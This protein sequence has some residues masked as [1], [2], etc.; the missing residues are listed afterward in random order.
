MKRSAFTLIE[1]LVVIAIIA[2]LAAILFPVFAQA[3]A[4]AKKTAAL[5]NMK[6]LGTAI[7]IYTSDNDDLYPSVY[8]GGD[9]FNRGGDPICTMYPYVKNMQIWTGYRQ[10]FKPTSYS[11]DPAVGCQRS[12][13]DVGYNWGWEIRAAEG[14]IN[15]ERCEDG[16][17][18]AGCTGRPFNGRNA[19][20]YNT[21]KSETQVANPADLFAF[22]NSYDTPRQTMGGID[23]FFDDYPG[24]KRNSDIYFGGKTTVTFADSHAKSVAWHG[25]EISGGTLIGS[26]KSFEQ[27]VKGYCADPDGVVN[28]FPRDSFPLGTGWICKDFLAYPEASGVVWWAD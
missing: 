3:K 13:N 9:V 20:R 12:N 1:L 24:G 16:G 28:P 6:Q 17:P 8:D 18:V 23:W 14:M 4:A 22:G 27:R 2:I 10:N 19:R 26:P 11:T 25:G 15:E 7:H 5:S 21:G